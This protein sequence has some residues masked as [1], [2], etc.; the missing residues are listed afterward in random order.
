MVGPYTL[1]VL[2]PETVR[3]PVMAA[4]PYMV[5]EPVTWAPAEDD[6]C[7]VC[8]HIGDNGNWVEKV[9]KEQAEDPRHNQ[10]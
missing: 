4:S 5:V 9:I 1:S 2:E 8:E 6:K 10:W 7:E 3:E